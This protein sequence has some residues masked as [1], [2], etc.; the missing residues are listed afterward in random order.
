MQHQE[1]AATEPLPLG[2]D[3]SQHAERTLAELRAETPVRRVVSNGVPAWLV[4]RHADVKRVLTGAEFTADPRTALSLLDAGS[5]LARQIEQ[6]GGH[7]LISRYVV[8]SLLYLDP[9]DH[10]RLRRLVSKAFTPGAVAR[11]RPRIEAMADEVVAALPGSGRIDLVTDFALHI[12]LTAIGELL[13]IPRADRRQFFDW[14]VI[15]NGGAD[16]QQWDQALHATTAY[17][18]ELIEKR[19]R[20]PEDD[21]LS[22]LIAARDDDGRLSEDELIAMAL[23]ILF[24]GHDTTVTLITNSVLAL[25]ADPEAMGAVRADPALLDDGVDELVRFH[26]PVNITTP[27]YTLRPV[28]VG[29]VLIPAGEKILI[30]LLSA[31]QDETQFPDAGRLDLH[32]KP[33]EHLGF[34]HGIHYCIGAPLARMET[35]IA[36]R[37]LL[38]RFPELRLATEPEALRYRATN[39]FHSLAEVPVE[40]S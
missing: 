33:S 7:P 5:A 2:P 18:A 34:G 25:L 20:E 36:L 26:T 28:T 30:S 21:L 39:L 4:T 15:I 23:L 8:T 31:N 22:G 6:F 19:R 27:R 29:D 9:P 16:P 38:A 1:T 24:A 14:A 40:L 35:G 3:F 37:R 13:G 11:L 10:T 17:L 32:R 12:P